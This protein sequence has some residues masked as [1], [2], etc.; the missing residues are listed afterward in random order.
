MSL[1]PDPTNQVGRTRVHRYHPLERSL[2]DLLNMPGPS[3]PVAK[4]ASPLQRAALRG[5]LDVT[6]TARRA[7]IPY[8]AARGVTASDHT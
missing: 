2:T 8:P 7:T 4:Y 6:P 5:T 1:P 3:V